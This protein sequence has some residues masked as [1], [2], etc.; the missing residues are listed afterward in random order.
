M[1]QPINPWPQPASHAN[2]MQSMSPHHNPFN[3]GVGSLVFHYDFLELMNKE[4]DFYGYTDDGYFKLDSCVF[5]LVREPALVML[6]EKFIPQE[7]MTA[8]SRKCTISW[9]LTEA[10]SGLVIESKDTNHVL[11]EINF[12]GEVTVREPV[13]PAEPIST[14]ITIWDLFSDRNI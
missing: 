6:R 1:P 9:K 5:Y 7:L 11:L 3:Q 13:I 10:F 8:P 4:F 2:N 12:L 14:H